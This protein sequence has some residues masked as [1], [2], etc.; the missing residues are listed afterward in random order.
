MGKSCYY[1]VRE[2]ELRR[3]LRELAPAS[4]EIVELQLGAAHARLVSA[5]GGPDA[6]RQFPEHTAQE[7][8]GRDRI[9]AGVNGLHA[10]SRRLDDLKEAPVQ[11]DDLLH[12][13]TRVAEE[14]I[15]E[16]DESLI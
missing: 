15:R 13:A 4:L 2:A 7:K 16:A 1:E 3:G 8:R 10:A 14:A 11:T 5:Y 6:P 12:E 9:Q